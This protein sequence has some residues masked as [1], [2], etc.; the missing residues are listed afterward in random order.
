MLLVENELF[1]L[2]IF[3]LNFVMQSVM[4]TRVAE[5]VEDMFFNITETIS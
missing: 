5:R 4:V 3:N 1:M 2:G